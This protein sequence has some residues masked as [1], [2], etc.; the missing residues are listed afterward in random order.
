MTTRYYLTIVE[1]RRA[2]RPAGSTFASVTRWST[3]TTA[4][5]RSAFPVPAEIRSWISGRQRGGSNNEPA[6]REGANSMKASHERN[7]RSDAARGSGV[8]VSVLLRQA[9]GFE[10]SFFGSVCLEVGHLPLAKSERV[11]DVLGDRRT[12]P[13]SAASL[14]GDHDY[15]SPASMNSFTSTCQSKVPRICANHSLAASRPRTRP[16]SGRPAELTSMD[17]SA[18]SSTNSRSASSPPRFMTSTPRRTSSTFSCDIVRAV[19][20][21]LRSRRERIAPDKATALRASVWSTKY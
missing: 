16:T 19:S 18:T 21:R 15:T 7:V 9:G 10:G 13:P 5:S 1:G 17:G 2:A 3:D 4:T 14:S 20:R 11:H 12:A 8:G 6:P